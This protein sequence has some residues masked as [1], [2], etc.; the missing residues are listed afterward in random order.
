MENTEMKSSCNE[1]GQ[2]KEHEKCMELLE[3]ILDGEASD[4]DKQYV[5]SHVERCMP[6]YRAYNLEKEIRKVLKNNLHQKP[7]PDDL[8]NS[9]KIKIRETV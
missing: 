3:L 1:Q 5:N 8:V 4:Q 2:C 9:I 6:C 7:V